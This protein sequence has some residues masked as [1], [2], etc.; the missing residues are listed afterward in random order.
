MPELTLSEFKKLFWTRYGNAN[1]FAWAIVAV[2]TYYWGEVLDWTAYIGGCDLTAH[3]IDAVQWIAANGNKLHW[4]DG[5][6]FFPD[7]PPELYRC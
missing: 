4:S 6:Y 5:K 7:L 3:E 1:D 2:V